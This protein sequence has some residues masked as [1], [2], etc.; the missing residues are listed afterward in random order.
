MRV[1][2]SGTPDVEN[3]DFLNSK[4]I[5]HSFVIPVGLSNLSLDTTITNMTFSTSIIEKHVTFER[6]DCGLYE[7]FLLEEYGQKALC[8]AT[9]KARL[10]LGKVDHDFKSSEQGNVKLRQ[11]LYFI[12]DSNVSGSIALDPVHCVRPELGMI[13]KYMDGI[14]GN[15]GY[16]NGSVNN[17]TRMGCIAKVVGLLEHSVYV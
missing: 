17:Q 16:Q 12:K 7:M 3:Y 14:A 13:P 8:Y 10:F 9:K 4:D 2:S 6:N 1:I 11:S 15:C 5:H